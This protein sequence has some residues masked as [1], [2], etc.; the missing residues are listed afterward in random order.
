MQKFRA[1]LVRVISFTGPE[2]RPETEINRMGF[3]EIISDVAR[4]KTTNPLQEYLILLL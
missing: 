1:Q 3:N 2:Q 4:S